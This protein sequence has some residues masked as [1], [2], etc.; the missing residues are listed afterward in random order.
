MI[1]KHVNCAKCGKKLDFSKFKTFVSMGTVT[2]G[3]NNPYVCK[4]CF[5][6]WQRI[7]AKERRNKSISNNVWKTAFEKWIGYA[8]DST[9]ILPEKVM[10]T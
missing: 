3:E 10:F 4:A 7:L 6:K 1:V 9:D 5:K 2:Y 8:W